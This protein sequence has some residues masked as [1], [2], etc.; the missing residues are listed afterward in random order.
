MKIKTLP[1]LIKVGLTCNSGSEPLTVLKDA[2]L[3]IHHGKFVAIMDTSGS[4]KPTILNIIGSLDKASTGAYCV[5]GI[6]A[7]HLNGNALAR[8]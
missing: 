6:D 3:T 5:R 2:C 1:E 7:A 8:E 4:G